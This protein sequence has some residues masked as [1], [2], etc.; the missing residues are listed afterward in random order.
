MMRHLL[1]TRKGIT[2]RVR[3]YRRQTV[4]VATSCIGLR[5]VHHA[6][7]SV[8]TIREVLLIR[9]LGLLILIS[10]VVCLAPA[11]G[12]VC[13][14][15]A[16]TLLEQENPAVVALEESNRTT[17][18][19]L[20]DAVEILMNLDR[21]ELAKK[22]IKKL[23]AADLSEQQLAGVHKAVGPG[24]FLRILQ[25]KRLHPEGETLADAVLDAA[26]RMARDPQRLVSLIGQLGNPSAEARRVV[27]GKLQAAGTAAVPALIEALT[28]PQRA[29]LHSGV[30][31]ALVRIGSVAV[32]PLLGVLGSPDEAL[33]IET[34]EA[35]GQL[36]AR[37]ATAYLIRPYLSTKESEPLRRAAGKALRQ[38]VGVAPHPR[39]AQIYL[40]RRVRAHYDGELSILGDGQD[41]VELW[42]YSAES[43]KSE[44]ARYGADDAALVVAA[45]LAE[46]LYALWPNKK[47][48][49]RLYLTTTLESAKVVSGFDRP[50]PRGAG[51]TWELVAA[52]GAAAI[53]DLLVHAIKT[54]RLPAAVGAAEVLGDIADEEIL[55]SADGL[56]RPLAEALAHSDRRLRF[57]AAT[58]IM[59]IN[60]TR[61]YPGSS[62]LP[63]TLAYLA[64]T[65]GAR[66][67]L[68][69]HPRTAQ[70]QSLVGILATLGFDGQTAQTGRQLFR[71]AVESPDCEMI[72][73]S[74]AIDRPPA[75]ELAQ[76]LRRD[77]RTAGLPIGLMARGDKLER[78]QRLAESDP[79]MIAFPQPYGQEAM[80]FQVQ[81][82]IACA[83]RDRVRTPERTAHA[84]AALTWLAQ[85]AENPRRYAFYDLMRHEEAVEAAVYVPELSADAA[86]VLGFTGSARA[87][88]ALVDVASEN[89]RP[90][91]HRQAAARAFAVAAKRRGVL[92]TTDDLTRQYER[93]NR[94][95]LL[96]RD[97]QA[98]LGSILDT[99]EAKRSE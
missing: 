82:L 25:D 49:R 17:P 69:G 97:T 13:A 57:A 12:P 3:S 65:T 2:S 58:A 87:Q 41:M 60:P 70:A 76:W 36:R 34:I 44:P 21:P 83:G 19:E 98:V 39:D 20:I 38:I 35:L 93:Y 79:R 85:L 90:L 96:D 52:Q 50:L 53:E 7:A 71:L 54:G 27:I 1:G 37:R 8:A 30:R 89:L 48:H 80:T 75:H 42:H 94:S 56:P 4:E 5:P 18:A 91:A 43:N 86:K 16:G 61:T 74:D 51:S 81:R 11:A 92:L 33:R 10:A 9:V 23:L 63:Q 99:I 78:A 73:L 77:L 68:I 67:V 59:S 31:E 95:E 40:A 62:R 66:R 64:G 32:E 15:E 29:N 6:L 55:H 46:D 45:E 28:D 26:H 88:R 84:H 24:V 14:Q 47:E 72:F 22:Y